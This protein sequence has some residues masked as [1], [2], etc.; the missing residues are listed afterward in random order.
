MNRWAIRGFEGCAASREAIIQAYMHV[1]WDLPVSCSAAPKE[2]RH[3]GMALSVI[4]W[5]LYVGLH[6]WGQIILTMPILTSDA[7]LRA[8]F[9]IHRHRSR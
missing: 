9:A 5:I 6:A 8:D 4:D 1:A 3:Y 7:A 2:L